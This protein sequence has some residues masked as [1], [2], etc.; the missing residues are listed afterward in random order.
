MG[1]SKSKE[2]KTNS[3]DISNVHFYDRLQNSTN[4][5]NKEFV[6]IWVDEKCK[7]NNLDTLR[8]QILL[9]QINNNNCLFFDNCQHFFLEIDRIR[10]ENFRILVILSGSLTKILPKTQ[11]IISTIII[12]CEDSTK[13]LNISRQYSNVV[14]VCTDHESL[15]SSIENEISSLK[16]NLF[17]NQ[18]LKSVHSLTFSEDLT[19]CDA[20]FSYIFFLE[21]LKQM[22][23]TKQAKDLMLNKCQDYY[24]NDKKQYLLIELFRNTYQSDEAIHWYIKDSFIYRLVNRAFRTENI[25]LWYLFRFYL[26]DLCKQLELIHKEQNIQTSLILYRGQS[27]M[28]IKEFNY[29]KSNIGSFILANGFFSSTTDIQI[30]NSFLS[31]AINTEDYKVILFKI[32]VEQSIVDKII[33]VDIDKYVGHVGECEILFSI[34]SIFQIEN[35]DF[36]NELNVWQIDIKAID[37][38]T[39]KVKESIETIRKRYGNKEN[40]N[41]IFGNLLIDMNQYTKAES[42][43]QMILQE[44]TKNHYDIPL[45]YDHLAD[46]FMKITNWNEAL[47]Y[48]NLSF[49]LKKKN[50]YFYQSNISITLNGIGNYY[51][52]IGNFN[53]ASE[54]YCQAMKYSN[55]N[56]YNM[57]IILNNI[58]TID[59]INKNYE[60]A[61]EKCIQARDILQEINSYSLNEI[62]YCHGI[63]GDIYLEMKNYL[64]AEE[65]YLTTFEMSKNILFIGDKIK[66]NSIKSLIYLYKQQGLIEKALEFSMNQLLWYEKYF[67]DCYSSIANIYMEISQLYDYNHSNH[68]YYLEKALNIFENNIHIQY[69]ITYQCFSFIA[70]YYFKKSLFDKSR[71]YYL[72]TLEIQK[73]IY[74]K[75][76][77]IIIQTQS[78]I[79]DIPIEI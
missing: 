1:N 58:S 64:Y 57:A 41:L 19:N 79:D 10:N 9:K 32:I 73:K 54:Y 25:T 27:R 76:H 12:F 36:N 63:I 20:F 23:Q 7:E 14:D 47:K 17:S 26:I 70:N 68:I 75:D 39:S 45:I 56:Q 6:L 38:N 37:Q 30:A 28:S 11:N 53:Q 8:T 2:I 31:G 48:F 78:I 77:S 46:L 24:R 65:F 33:F 4:E 52:S 50:L 34:G 74:P 69:L 61:L 18:T 49:E 16:L 40:I 35:V 15:K 22:P 55:N 43:F 42:Y 44:L 51:K 71:K 21:L 72:K 59:L 29:L 13:Y 62:I 67:P 66:I 3:I 60:K 5:T